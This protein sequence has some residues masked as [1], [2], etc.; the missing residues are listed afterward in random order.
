MQRTFW[1]IA[2]IVAGAAQRFFRLDH[3]SLWWDEAWQFY[4]CGVDSLQALFDRLLDP[5]TT[6]N[7]TGSH[8]VSF[9]F[10]NIDRSDVFLRLPSFPNPIYPFTPGPRTD[11]SRW[12]STP[13]AA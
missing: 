3:Q 5:S 6:A 7:P 9:A 1:V 8:L 13:A 12:T 2:L 4:V 10:L 11:T